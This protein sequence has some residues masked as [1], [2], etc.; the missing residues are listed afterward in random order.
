MLTFWLGTAVFIAVAV[1]MAYIIWRFRAKDSKDAEAVPAQVHGNTVAEIA[2]WFLP[3]VLL[4]F[5]AVPTV[6]L[7]WYQEAVEKR[8]AE[9]ELVVNVTGYQWWWKF[10]YPE[11][12]IVTANE[13]HI[14][15]GRRVTLNLNSADVLHSF[16]V[17]KLAGKKDIIPNQDNVL[18]FIAD[19]LESDESVVY[20][21]QCAELCLGSHA[22]MR[23]RVVVDKEETFDT[24]VEKFQNAKDNPI[25]TDPAVVRGQQAF[26][27]KGCAACHSVYND[28][29][30]VG[31]DN[32]PDLTNFGLRH[33]VGAGVKENSLENLKTWIRDPQEFKPANYMPTLWSGAEGEE[34][35]IED[36]A[37]FLQSLGN[38]DSTQ[39][40]R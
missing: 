21:G 40:S 18:W 31:T 11:Y 27:Q 14:P 15:E 36:I 32:R 1:V 29:F 3:I 25:S 19:E 35:Q 28:D 38:E 13:L 9:G 4:F 16:W 12:G 26:L 20:Y 2:W 7:T 6:K 37:I 34:E 30:A 24:W 17:P 39:S 23:F 10:E 22:Y 8:T 33:T 5:I